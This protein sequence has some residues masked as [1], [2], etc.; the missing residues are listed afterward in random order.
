VSL[1]GEQKAAVLLMSLPEEVRRQLL[2]R[3]GDLGR[4]LHERLQ[5]LV[6]TPPDATL[7]EA[8]AGEVESALRVPAPTPLARSPASRVREAYQG[9]SDAGPAGRGTSATYQQDDLAT[10]L[11]RLRSTD[12]GEL[13][14]ALQGE[15]PAAIALVLQWLDA[16]QAARV[17]EALPPS[18]VVAVSQRF[19]TG[20]R[21]NTAL[22]KP[23]LRALAW[24]LTARSLS[25]PEVGTQR[26][27]WLAE[28]LRTLGPR[29]RSTLLEAL[30]AQYPAVVQQVRRLVYRME[31]LLKLPDAQVQRAIRRLD[32][33]TLAAALSSASPELR[34]KILSN[35]SERVRRV[36]TEEWEAQRFEESEVAAAVTKLTD[37]LAELE[38]SGEP[39]ALSAAA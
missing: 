13:A 36:L 21:S 27:T 11:Q 19:A 22:A 6:S 34:A 7:V 24:K 3:L 18:L 10:Y 15:H 29:D 28:A 1:R 2:Q 35:V 12:P 30:A 37:A 25:Q 31:D 5:A 20:L 9:V 33:R 17:L 4:R 16:A 14:E 23:M 8:V 39:L 32:V 26:L 38:A